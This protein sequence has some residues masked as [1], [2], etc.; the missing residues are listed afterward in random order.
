MV[1]SSH[2]RLVSDWVLRHPACSL[3]PKTY[4]SDVPQKEVLTCDVAGLG[5]HEVRVQLFPAAAPPHAVV[6]STNAPEDATPERWEAQVR[7]RNP[8][9]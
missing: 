7:S 2:V 4:C 5:V 9:P 8:I 6:V 1:D 3:S